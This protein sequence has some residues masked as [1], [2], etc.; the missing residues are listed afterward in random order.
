[1]NNDNNNNYDDKTNNSRKQNK[2][3]YKIFLILNSNKQN[4]NKEIKDDNEKLIKLT[5][6]LNILMILQI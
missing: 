5:E 1:M 6:N 2:N 4:T 3:I